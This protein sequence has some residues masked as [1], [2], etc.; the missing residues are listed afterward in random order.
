[1]SI[2]VNPAER[3]HEI[4]SNAKNNSNS[5]NNYGNNNS[6]QKAWALTFGIDE[7]DEEKVFMAVV[8]VIQQ[9]EALKK[10]ANRM[11]SNLKN[12]FVKQ[13]TEL[14]REIMNLKLS[15]DSYNLSNIIN[16]KKIFSLK[17][18]GMG[19]DI[20][21][22]YSTIEDEQM[23]DIREKI[24]QLINEINDLS[25]NDDL[26]K[27]VIGN[28]SSVDLMIENHKLYGVDGIKEAVEKGFGNIMLN[29]ELSEL[30]KSDT[31][32]KETLKK[33]LNLFGSIN[34]VLTFS[35]NMTPMLK[36]ATEIA[37]NFFFN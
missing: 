8:Q 29:N 14:E 33:V 9:I 10:V 25:I 4:L 23:H 24:L 19:L 20:Y 28:L 32:V 2:E 3:L 11:N 6:V 21:N 1:M 31:T 5:S 16:E 35:K 18:I 26:K 34:T 17:A 15:E 13:I 7:N 36:E 27:I 37:K 22:E 12:D 30:S